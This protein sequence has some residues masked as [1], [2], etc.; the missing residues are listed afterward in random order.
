MTQKSKILSRAPFVEFS[1]QLTKF[2]PCNL[3]I[4]LRLEQLLNGKA[5]VEKVA[6]DEVT[7]RKGNQIAIFDSKGNCQ[8][9]EDYGYWRK[10]KEK[11]KAKP[12]VQRH[13]TKKPE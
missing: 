7:L 12:Q 11:A 13:E 6:T 9:R 2:E 5:R 3:V 1:N 8:W 4:W 10:L